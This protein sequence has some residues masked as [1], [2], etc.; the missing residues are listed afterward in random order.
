MHWKSF[1]ALMATP[2]LLRMCDLVLMFG[3]QII[4]VAAAAGQ[5]RQESTPLRPVCV[6]KAR[7]VL[8]FSRLVRT[9]GVIGNRFLYPTST[10]SSYSNN[11]R[12]GHRPCSRQSAL[13]NTSVKLAI[14]YVLYTGGSLNGS[15]LLIS[16]VISWMTTMM[17][18]NTAFHCKR[19]GGGLCSPKTGQSR[20]KR[21]Y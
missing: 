13:L 10:F 6:F 15:C 16:L 4:R 14:Y 5:V 12:P 1:D 17:Q 19:R 20:C 9:R 7:C 18:V 11:I 8:M 21:P 3:K 2:P